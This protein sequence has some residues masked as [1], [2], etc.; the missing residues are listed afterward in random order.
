MQQARAAAFAALWTLCSKLHDSWDSTPL[1]Q[2]CLQDNSTEGIKA[3]MQRFMDL[4][5]AADP[6]LH[7]HLVV[8]NKVPPTQP[9]CPGTALASA[10]C[11]DSSCAQVNAQFY[12]F[13]WITLLL[14]QEFPF[15][16]VVRLWDSLLAAPQGRQTA[17]LR[18]CTAMLLHVRQLLLEVRMVYLRRGVP[19]P[20]SSACK[21]CGNGICA[22]PPRTMLLALC[23]LVH[24]PCM[25]TACT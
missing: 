3:T 20:C 25:C 15:P 9:S 16:D 21:L 18:L 11:P 8:A 24:V 13:R 5:Q 12:A 1:R 19:V 4:L 10:P 6:E 22:W 7:A 17:L 14:T 2:R 23:C